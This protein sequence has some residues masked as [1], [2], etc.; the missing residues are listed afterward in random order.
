VE[1]LGSVTII[2]SDKTGTLTRNEMTAK[3]VRTADEDIE[4]E[5]VGYQ[6]EGGFL[7][8]GNEVNLEE[9]PD[10]PGNG[11]RRNA[12]QRRPADA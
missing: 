2:C 5:G 11:A 7:L 12:V 10:R 9:N 6:P 1:T 8:D 3:T 4:V